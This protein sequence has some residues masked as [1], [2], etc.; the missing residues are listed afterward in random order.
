VTEATNQS[1]NNRS[2]QKDFA[3]WKKS[4]PYIGPRAFEANDR[5]F[6]FG[7]ERESNDL[8]SLIIAN[9]VVLLY[10]KSGVGKSSL[11]NAKLKPM[12]EKAEFEILPNVRLLNPL[13]TARD[14]DEEEISNIFVFNTISSITQARIDFEKQKTMTLADYLRSLTRPHDEEGSPLPR[15][16]LF[17]QFEEIFT[18]YPHRWQD[19]DNFFR[20]VGEALIEQPKQR[21]LFS[22][23]EEYIAHLETYA[24]FIPGNF[25]TR[26]RLENLRREQ[27][28]YAVKKP[29]QALKSKMTL[30]TGGGVIP[31]Y[32][33]GVP[34]K[35]VADLMTISVQTSSGRSEK[36]QGEFVEPVQLQIVCQNLWNNLP[37]DTKEI[38]ENQVDTIGNADQALKNFYDSCIRK[39]AEKS[40]A[41]EGKLRSL[42]DEHLITPAAT[43]GMVFKD[44]QK[45]ETAGIPNKAMELLAGKHLIR[46]DWRSGSPWYELTHDRLIQPVLESNRAF[47]LSKIY[48]LA[49]IDKSQLPT[50]IEL[51]G[52]SGDERAVEP[53]MP[54]IGSDEPGIRR[55]AIRALGRLKSP[56]AVA[57]ILEVLK[58]DESTAR[59]EAVIALGEIGDPRA[60]DPLIKALQDPSE[61]I[62]TSAA[63]ALEKMSWKPA[64]DHQKAWY[65]FAKKD[66]Q[67]SVEL[68]QPSIEPLVSSLRNTDI[69][70]RVKAINALGEIGDEQALEPLMNAFHDMDATVRKAVIRAIGKIDHERAF[71]FLIDILQGQDNA[72]DQSMRL[73]A[74]D[75]VLP[76]MGNEVLSSLLRTYAEN[77]SMKLT[78][79]MNVLLSI[80]G[81]RNPMSH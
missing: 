31:S 66:W 42:F 16:I 70:T 19:R 55:A 28:L 58:D 63:T 67:A 30:N 61:K 22:I 39:T 81:L 46:L 17:D 23:R 6:F 24:Q 77:E 68:G 72:N 51:I 10:A 27:A 25:S 14:R 79:E 36:K 53:L 15:L 76:L 60:V 7:R 78:D 73:L 59:E 5:E 35:I 4:N 49:G 38:T 37:N 33:E 69:A 8:F 50:R 47:R 29:I 13:P 12:L 21:A 34:G 75:T 57:R 44:E 64:D 48:M 40:G 26:Y 1:Q 3:D 80:V 9:K 54:F 45:G 20:Q 2:A 32:G 52:N 71:Q 56:K 65:F 11:L 43:K 41:A 62:A 18:N 74:M